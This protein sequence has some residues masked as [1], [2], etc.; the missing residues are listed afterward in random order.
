MSPAATLGYE[1]Q[2]LPQRKREQS[3]CKLPKPQLPSHATAADGSLRRRPRGGLQDRDRPPRSRV[4]G[5]SH[6]RF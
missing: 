4:R 6:A 5:N 2:S 3:V 1:W